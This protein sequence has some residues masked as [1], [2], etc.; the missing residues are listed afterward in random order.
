MQPPQIKLPGSAFAQSFGSEAARYDAYRPSYPDEAVAWALGELYPQRLLDLGA[1]TGKLTASLLGRAETVLAVDPDEAMLAYLRTALPQVRAAV[2]SAEATGLPTLSVDAVLAAQAFHWFA[3]PGVDREL[4]RIVRPRGV[5]GLI[6]NFP[7]RDVD[8][9]TELYRTIGDRNPPWTHQYDPLDPADFE[10]ADTAYF[11]SGHDLD[12]PDG[13]RNLVQ[14]W[15]WVITRPAA[16]RAEID[17][18]VQEL[19]ER[20]PALQ[21][22]RVTMP[23]TTKV[24]RVVRR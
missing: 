6:W 24:V 15:S 11:P 23:Q 8:W 13:L 16:E 1:G 14:T 5:V 2:G 3:R 10:P 17:G 12:G 4:A 9:V 7:D 21:G 19:I 18:R 20:T 22:Q